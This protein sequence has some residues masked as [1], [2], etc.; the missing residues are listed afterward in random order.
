MSLNKHLESP[1]LIHLSETWETL[2][3][4]SW[5]QME[6]CSTFSAMSLVVAA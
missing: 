1:D 3:A 5:M 4:I 6:A 2:E